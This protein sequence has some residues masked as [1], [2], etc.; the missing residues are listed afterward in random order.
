MYSYYQEYI[1]ILDSSD[2]FG[3][4]IKP[5]QTNFYEDPIS[6]EPP[7]FPSSQT[8]TIAITSSYP[9]SIPANL[10]SVKQ[11]NVKELLMRAKAG[12]NTDDIEK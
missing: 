9:S 4:Q 12:T 3:L 7:D 8:S 5:T 11:S 10:K 6:M 1:D 2:L